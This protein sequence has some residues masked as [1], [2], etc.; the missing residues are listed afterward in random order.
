MTRL[1]ALRKIITDN[2]R[3][4]QGI[5]NPGVR[6]DRTLYEAMIDIVDG[7]VFPI[8]SLSDVQITSVPT[9]GQVLY[10]DSSLSAWV[11]ENKAYLDEVFFD[12]NLATSGQEGKLHWNVDDGT[13]QIGLLG[14]N[15][16][17]DIGQENLVRINNTNAYDLNIG[18]AVYITGAQGQRVTVELANS[19]TEA[20]SS[21]TLGIVAEPIP[22]GSEGFIA[23]FG[24]V[25]NVNT[26]DF[27][28]GR[29]LYLDSTDGA[30]TIDKPLTPEHM[31][32]VG[33]CVRQQQSSGSI[34][35]TVNNGYELEEIHDVLISTDV[36]SGET[37]IYNGSYWENSIPQVS[38]SGTTG[39][40]RVF[41]ARKSIC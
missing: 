12:P 38:S 30:L 21:K 11:P 39:R 35:V 22:A 32:L 24:L 19:Q 4:L 34:F 7:E 6:P 33:F 20:T 23:T 2:K 25:R 1:E 16:S 14:G 28:E 37:L 26:Q 36:A 3:A 27:P 15:I 10:Y 8:D 13:L 17:L 29:A 41:R 9:E 31:V 40:I 18:Q 5:S